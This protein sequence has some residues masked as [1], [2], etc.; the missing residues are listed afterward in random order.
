MRL[1][2]AVPLVAALTIGLTVPAAGADAPSD[3]GRYAQHAPAAGG[4]RPGLL[5][6]HGRPVRERRPDE[7]PRRAAPAT[8]LVTGFDPTGKGFYH[9]GDLDGPASSSS[10]TSRASAPTRSG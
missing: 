7:R 5:L 9:G 4:H 6:R 8:A 2:H 1:L 3:H 10:T